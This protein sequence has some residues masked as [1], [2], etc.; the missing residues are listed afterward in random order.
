MQISQVNVGLRF[1]FI[2]WET[3]AE[4]DPGPRLPHDVAICVVLVDRYVDTD[5]EH[6]NRLHDRQHQV[7][8]LVVVAAEDPTLSSFPTAHSGVD[9]FKSTLPLTLCW[10]TYVKPLI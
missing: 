10:T 3:M 4:M 5:H 2:E 7:S 8:G 6:W 9:I 1:H